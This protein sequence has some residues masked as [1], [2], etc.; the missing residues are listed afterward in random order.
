M[1]MLSITQLSCFLISFF[2][3]F[4]GTREGGAAG[5]EE[6][7]FFGKGVRV[8][9]LIWLRRSFLGWWRF[10]RVWVFLFWENGW[11]GWE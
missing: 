8:D 11:M 6:F 2:F 9:W 7:A 5:G 10:G 3:F 4:F 1:N